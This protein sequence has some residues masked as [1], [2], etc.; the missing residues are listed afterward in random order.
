MKKR[1]FIIVLLA[2]FLSFG[3]FGCSKKQEAEAPAVS[4]TVA[5]TPEKHT[6]KNPEAPVLQAASS[7]ESDSQE[8]IFNNQILKD[9]ILVE[10]VRSKF[11]VMQMSV[12]FSKPQEGF[13]EAADW[14]E[15]HD[16]NADQELLAAD[17]AIKNL[18]IQFGNTPEELHLTW[19]SKSSE[20][21]AVTFTTEDGRRLIGLVTT[22]P[23]I[24]V[25]GYYQNRA[26]ISGLQADTYYSYR[27]ANGKT[28]SPVYSYHSNDPYAK[29]FSFMIV[30]DQELG[31]GDEEDNVLQNQGNAWRLC[32]N[33]MK[34]R[35]PDSAFILSLGD[36]VAKLDEP[37]QYDHL[38]DKSVLYS[39]PF[40]PVVGNHDVGSGY[41]GDH[42]YPPNISP[43]GTSQGEDGDYWFV[44]GN[45]LFMIVNT[46]TVQPVDTHEAF[47]AEAIA[48][49]PNVKW[50]VVA[51]HYS[52]AS[53]VEKYQGIRDS[54]IPTFTLIAEQHNIDLFL[55]A[56]DHVYTRSYFLNSDGNPIDAGEGL[57][58]E[59]HNPGN[60]IYLALNTCTGSLYRWP[61][62]YPWTAISSQDF[63]P[64][65]S[66]AHVTENSFTISTY[67][68]DSWS[69]VD[70]FTIYK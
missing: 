24:S 14:N 49:N 40:L 60:P 51:S 36:Q 22:K 37:A 38:L 54:I 69:L 34:E 57:R 32:L 20:Q 55:G 28:A 13:P 30:T 16:Y 59:F 68:A 70:S 58:G 17:G 8:S 46:L 67:N 3:M 19:F 9:S 21:G 10:P 23:S 50:R 48:K 43:I 12:D 44:R 56:H 6:T 52:P 4:E 35:I 15:T 33:R 42:F 45:V 2:S 47:V 7:E 61:E 11:P 18:S 26:V 62:D 64:Q 1:L 66:Q 63:V 29:E 27:V 39:T 5:A 53:N 41:W 25:P 31:L 65:V